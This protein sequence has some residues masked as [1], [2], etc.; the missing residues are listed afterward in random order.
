MRDMREMLCRRTP[1]FVLFISIPVS[2]TFFFAA[3]SWSFVF[4]FVAAAFLTPAVPALFARRLLTAGG[5]L[6]VASP[7]FVATV[8]FAFF[9]FGVGVSS[10]AAP[11]HAAF[12]D[13]AGGVQ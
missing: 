1:P 5:R 6:F 3:A 12:H 13:V 10:S 2:S 8:R 9:F 4:F 11:R 7:F